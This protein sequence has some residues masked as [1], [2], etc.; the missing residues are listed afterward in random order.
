MT[1]RRTTAWM[2]PVGMMAAWVTAVFAAAAL[3]L[4]SQGGPAA[5]QQSE[6]K[7]SITQIGGG[8]Y[9]FQNNFHYSVF[10]VT[11]AGVIVTDPIDAEAA[12][13]LK[14][15]IAERF[16]Q[17]VRYLVYSHDHRDHIA[18]GE[19]FAED[20]AVVIAHD[21]TKEAIIGEQRPTAVPDITFEDRMTVTLGS[22]TVEMIYVGPGHSDN[23]IV[24]HFPAER[25]VFAV[26]FISVKRL[27][28]RTLSDAYFPQWMDAIRRVEAIDFDT[29]VPGHG[30]IGTKADASDHREYL[31]D[32][33]DAVLAGLRAGQSVEEMKASIT[34][35]AYKDWGQ[36]DA[37][38]EENIEGMAANLE[39]HRRGN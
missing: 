6:V 5:A 17:P 32:L 4:M 13:W 30:N 15:E 22:H 37:W 24:L 34:L 12:R 1:A 25:A 28:F 26:D 19:V 38:R 18:G 3:V 36:Y 20:G 21:R 8:L 7:R 31:Q 35:D 2:R 10:L 11:E 23:S 14:A 39:L 16:A 29:L 9:R 33:Y 27:P